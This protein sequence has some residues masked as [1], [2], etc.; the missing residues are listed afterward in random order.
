MRGVSLLTGSA[1]KIRGEFG[2]FANLLLDIAQLVIP[3]T[4]V[5]ALLHPLLAALGLALL[6]GAA[7]LAFD[8][9]ITRPGERI[10][11]VADG[12]RAA[13]CVEVAA[14]CGLETGAVEFALRAGCR[15]AGCAAAW[16]T[17][18]A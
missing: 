4:A 2:L 15:S 13:V 12:S 1:A 10:V 14:G 5:A 17:E 18:P 9:S 6:L 3:A 7:Q 8:V 11:R 16:G